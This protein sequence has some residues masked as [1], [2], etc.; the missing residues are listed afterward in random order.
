MLTEIDATLALA[1]QRK[2]PAPVPR[3]SLAAPSNPHGILVTH[4]PSPRDTRYT[5]DDPAPFFAAGQRVRGD[6]AVQRSHEA[7]GKIHDE[8]KAVAPW[9]KIN[10]EAHPLD[11]KQARVML[12]MSNADTGNTVIREADESTDAKACIASAQAEL[13]KRGSATRRAIRRENEPT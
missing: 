10:W 7:A 8:F 2:Q 9:A 6:T 1:V 5:V 3:S 13:R 12:V 4:C 11:A